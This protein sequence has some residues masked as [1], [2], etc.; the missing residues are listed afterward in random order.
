MLLFVQR[1]SS[2]PTWHRASIR[3]DVVALVSYLLEALLWT[4]PQTSL[5]VHEW[6]QAGSPLSC[7][8]PGLT[9]TASDWIGCLITDERDPEMEGDLSVNLLMDNPHPRHP[10][11]HR[12][13]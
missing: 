12:L 4:G 10:P 13:I 5:L 1:V 3:E 11:D 2:N 9:S 7:P 6:Y 8:F